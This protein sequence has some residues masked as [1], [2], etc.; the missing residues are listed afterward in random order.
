MLRIVKVLLALSVALWAM[1]A[2]VQNF[3]NWDDIFVGV[4]IATSMTTFEPGGDSW[5][6]TSNPIVVWAG[7]FF[8]VFAK[9][10]TGVLCA[11]GAIRMW[12]ARRNDAAVYSAA[13][14]WF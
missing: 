6:A 10:A 3:D 2:A 13:K 14:E 1:A 11:V 7:G 8:I 5:Q 12:D 4:S 9:I